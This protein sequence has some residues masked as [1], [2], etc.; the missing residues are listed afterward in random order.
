MRVSCCWVA[1]EGVNLVG[2]GVD[3]VNLVILE[4]CVFGRFGLETLVW[5]LVAAIVW[6]RCWSRT[7]QDKL[8]LMLFFVED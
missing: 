2:L 5:V 4:V 6:V 3:V 8:I 1:G 7:G